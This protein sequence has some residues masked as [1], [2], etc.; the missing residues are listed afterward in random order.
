MHELFKLTMVG[1]NRRSDQTVIEQLFELSPD[2]L[3]AFKEEPE[4]LRGKVFEAVSSVQPDVREAWFPVVDAPRNTA[5][6][7]AWL[8]C[9]TAVLLQKSTGH[10]V[11]E[12]A[13]LPRESEQQ[14]HGY[15]EHE[16]VEVGEAAGELALSLLKS[17]LGAPNWQQADQY[18]GKEF[19]ELYAT[20]AGFTSPKVLPADTRAI[21]DAARRLEIPCIK[22]DRHPYR[23]TSGD[24]RI[25]PNS[26]LMLGQCRHLHLVD[27]TMCVDRS[28]TVVPIRSDQGAIFKRVADLLPPA[29]HLDPGDGETCANVD[30]VVSNHRVVVTVPERMLHESTRDIA[31]EVSRRLEVGLL[32]MKIST[33][34]PSRPL[35]EANGAV[36]NIDPAPRLDEVLAPDSLGMM[37]AAEGFVRWVIP[38]GTESRIPVVAVTGTNG[39]TTTSRMIDR[40][41]QTAGYRTSLLC[42][43]G[44][45]IDNRKLESAEV[46]ES[47]PWFRPFELSEVELAVQETHFGRILR[48]GFSYMKSD[49]AICTNVTVDHIGRLG[50][51]T[52]EQLAEV[53]LSV[54]Q[55]AAD[56]AVLN[57]D[58]QHCRDMIP[59]LAARRICL[60]S[61]RKGADELEEFATE[62]DMKCVLEN[63]DGSDWIVLYDQGR[64]PVIEVDKIPATYN[65][66]ARFNV[67]NAMYATVGS[68]TLG[69]GAD[70]IRATL[71][72][73]AMSVENAPGRLNIFDG[74]PFKVIMDYAHNEDGYREIGEFVASQDIRG[75]KIL[76]IA[77]TINRQDAALLENCRVAA[78]Y[79]DHLVIRCYPDTP[80]SDWQEETDR[81]EKCALKVDIDESQITAIANPDD[82][83]QTILSMGREGDCLVMTWG[84]KEAE[85]MWDA[86]TSFQPGGVLNHPV[87]S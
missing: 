60:V 16:V 10:D 34:D 82:G 86:I 49:V 51:E 53:K 56:T 47:D 62:Q 22:L 65:G 80:V 77:S 25:R 42:S 1:P 29:V 50:I 21:V 46:G 24:F 85:K 78:K 45:Y 27:G 63:V 4:I 66:T 44:F 58:D 3:T 40:I 28:S 72:G 71:L 43:D 61:T 13:V 14:A 48:G 20:F 32:L 36:V 6:I 74:H 30:I 54:M 12:F 35:D 68:H 19:K 57:F 76:L 52:L 31:I 79:F 7:F 83:V 41:M 75:R 5:E 55:R 33:S 38:A 70:S 9:G 37:A 26:M 59:Q 18:Q 87:R 2:E 23:G 64:H 67:Y 15:F 8:Y 84:H 11:L 81:M 69:A 17:T 39:K 73:F